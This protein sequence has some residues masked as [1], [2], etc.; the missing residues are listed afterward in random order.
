MPSQVDI[1]FLTLV[2]YNRHK[3]SS[4]RK[5]IHKKINL[6]IMSERKERILEKYFHLKETGPY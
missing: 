3:H 6:L 5:N 2:L 1:W 4:L